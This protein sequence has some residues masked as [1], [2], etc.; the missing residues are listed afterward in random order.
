MCPLNMLKSLFGGVK[1]L[2]SRLK[3]HFR[4]LADNYV[5]FWVR[6][7]GRQRFIVWLFRSPLIIVASLP[8]YSCTS[9][10][11]IVLDTGR[12]WT[13]WEHQIPDR[14]WCGPKTFQRTDHGRG[15]CQ[16]RI[17]TAG[18]GKWKA[19]RAIGCSFYPCCRRTGGGS[20]WDRSWW[21]IVWPSVEW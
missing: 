8:R 14:L 19:D 21:L 9:I 4:C 7:S 2:F 18:A 6:R 11:I 5:V 12:W 10:E 13:F 20:C 1:W 3:W 17:R 15:I 16:Y